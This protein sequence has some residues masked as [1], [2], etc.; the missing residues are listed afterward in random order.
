[1][2]GRHHPGA[3]LVHKHAKAAL[4]MRRH[5][6]SV[7]PNDAADLVGDVGSDRHIRLNEPDLHVRGCEPRALQL[8]VEMRLQPVFDLGRS[9]PPPTEDVDQIEEVVADKGYQSRTSVHDLE[10]LRVPPVG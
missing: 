3:I 6:L 9:L 10:T 2:K 8:R 7:R 5:F 4:A 1:V